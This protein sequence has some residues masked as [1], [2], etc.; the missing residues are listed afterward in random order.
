MKQTIQA[1]ETL[2]IIAI[3]L[4]RIIRLILFCLTTPHVQFLFFSDEQTDET[5]TGG[6]C[7]AALEFKPHFIFFFF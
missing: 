5:R 7:F 1:Y 4:I 6:F 3:Y 2:Y